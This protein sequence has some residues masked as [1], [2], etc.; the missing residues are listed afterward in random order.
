ME[1]P[2]DILKIISNKLLRLILDEVE[3]NSELLL[4][5]KMGYID[6]FF[7]KYIK[8]TKQYY[9]SPNNI[10]FIIRLLMAKNIGAA[11][12]IRNYKGHTILYLLIKEILSINY[13]GIEDT[14]Y[15]ISLD[16]IILLH[17]YGASSEIKNFHGNTVSHLLI[18]NYITSVIEGEMIINIIEYLQNLGMKINVVK[19][20]LGKTAY[21]M[22]LI[23]ISS[24]F[25]H[26]V[27]TMAEYHVTLDKLLFRENEIKLNS[28]SNEISKL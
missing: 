10:D 5:K 24:V 28:I 25:G 15:K 6:N 14:E 8:T 11:P 13:L 20:D 9:E 27:L 2:D 16:K 21:S 4:K 3:D 18:S 1:L 19:N 26:D 22:G 17:K 12:N 7:N 23:T